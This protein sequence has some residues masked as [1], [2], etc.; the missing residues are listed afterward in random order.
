MKTT[1]IIILLFLLI[2]MVVNYPLKIKWSFHFNVLK[3]IGFIVFKV[4]FIRLLSERVKIN[5]EF[6]FVAEKEKGEK[7]S[8]LF[9]KNYMLSLAKKVNVKNIDIICDLGADDAYFISVIS[10]S[11]LT[12]ISSV[13][14]F[15]LNKYEDV[16]IYYDLLP[17][18][19]EYQFELTGKIIVSFTIVDVFKSLIE[20]FKLTKRSEVYG[21]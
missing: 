20:A 15:I 8:S 17:N 19:N 2:L 7:K 1:L 13:I 10:G 21:K 18:Y 11:A 3:N 4:F 9:F 16:K 5:K 6:E 12:F 14:A